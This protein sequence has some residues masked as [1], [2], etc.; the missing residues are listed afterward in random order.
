MLKIAYCDDM[1]KDRESIM[2]FLGQIEAKWDEEFELYSFSSGESLCEDV[3]KNH[4]DIILL[5]IL[6]NGIDGIETATRIRAMGEENLI[7]FISSYDK[8]VK[9][10]FDFRTIAFLDKPVDISKLEIA[11]SKANL[12]LKNDSEKYFTF[13]SRGS[14]QHIPIKDIVYFES[15]RNEILIYTIKNQERFYSTL[16]SVWENIKDLD[17]FIMPHRS[18]IFNLHYVAIKSDKVIIK[19][20]EEMFNI[21]EKYR[22][23]TRNRH[24][25]FL[26]KRFK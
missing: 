11:L 10:L 3:A 6:M 23:D 12:I 17:Q 25:K 7:I 4:Y 20:T 24:I 21:G 18:F 8:R 14:I 5:D 26:E 9:E 16:L 22:Q 2:I 1:E 13:N 15:K 19:R